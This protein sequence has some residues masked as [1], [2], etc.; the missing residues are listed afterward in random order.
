MKQVFHY[1]NEVI[2]I[3]HTIHLTKD[4]VVAIIAKYFNTTVSNVHIDYEVDLMKYGTNI[5]N[6]YEEKPLA[7]ISQASEELECRKDVEKY[8]RW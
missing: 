2:K 3:L 5:I 4:D 1:R 8:P 6:S 7:I